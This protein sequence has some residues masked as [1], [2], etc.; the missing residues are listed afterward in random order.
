[1][2]RATLGI[3]FRSRGLSECPHRNDPGTCS[4][5]QLLPGTIFLASKAKGVIPTQS[6]GSPGERCLEDLAYSLA[7]VFRRRY[8]PQEEPPQHWVD[9]YVEAFEEGLQFPVDPIPA[10]V[11]SSRIPLWEYWT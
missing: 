7:E 3:N 11:S 5:S 9:L 4:R 6:S 1:M 10:I 2:H 8:R